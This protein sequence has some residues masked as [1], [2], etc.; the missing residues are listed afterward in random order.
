[1]GETQ[2]TEPVDLAVALGERQRLAARLL[3]V[4]VPQAV[5][6]T[7]RRRWRAAARDKGR[8]GRATRLALAAW[9]RCVTTGPVER[10][11]L[12]EALVRGRLRWQMA[13]LCKVW[14][15]HGRVDESRRTTPWRMLCEGSATLLAM[16][17]QHGVFLVSFWA[18]PDRSLTTAAQT[19]QKHALHLASAFTSVQRL[20]RALATVK[21]CLAAGCRM[22]RRNTHPNTYQLLLQATGP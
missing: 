18:S 4:R 8:Q 14:K 5:A 11:T 16:L 9:T 12:R 15:S 6:D 17:V 7:R 13:L 2:P 19:V 20:G 1:V 3:A 10:L 21:R 22:H